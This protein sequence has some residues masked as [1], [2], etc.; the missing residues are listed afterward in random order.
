MTILESRS[1]FT[2]DPQAESSLRSAVPWYLAPATRNTKSGGDCTINRT[3]PAPPLLLFPLHCLSTPLGQ[4]IKSSIHPPQP[5]EPSCKSMKM[6]R[7]CL[8]AALLF[9]LVILVDGTPEDINKS[10]DHGMSG[11]TSPLHTGGK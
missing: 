9:L 2:G 11:L 4:D 1:V 7:L 6:N 5:Q 10:H 8:S 3:D